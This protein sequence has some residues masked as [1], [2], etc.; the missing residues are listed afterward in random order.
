M[1]SHGPKGSKPNN[2]RAVN[3]TPIPCLLESPEDRQRVRVWRL[4]GRRTSMS[5]GKKVLKPLPPR[6]ISGVGFHERVNIKGE[7][8]KKWW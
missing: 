4:L 5:L 7:A 3:G 6:K 1:H 8:R 2:D